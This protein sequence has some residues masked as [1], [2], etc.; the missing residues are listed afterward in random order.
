ML[1]DLFGEYGAFFSEIEMAMWLP[2]FDGDIPRHIA[3][4]VTHR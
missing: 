3:M 2:F 4:G 1:N